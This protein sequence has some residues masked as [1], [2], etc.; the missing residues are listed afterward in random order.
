MLLD[1]LLP[2]LNSEYQNSFERHLVPN[3]VCEKL[4][5]ENSTHIVI[6]DLRHFEKLNLKIV[7]LNQLEVVRE[8]KVHSVMETLTR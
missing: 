7:L 5:Y 2:H 6:S 8:V 3:L 1:S 4:I